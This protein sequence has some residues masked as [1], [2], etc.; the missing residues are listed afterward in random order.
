[1]PSLKKTIILCVLVFAVGSFLQ[2]T[3]FNSCARADVIFSEDFEGTPPH[4]L[5]DAVTASRPG[6]AVWSHDAPTGWTLDNSNMGDGGTP[7][8]WGLSFV[9]KDWW[10]NPG[11]GRTNFTLGTNTI[12]VGESDEWDDIGHTG[13]FESYL[14]TK[15][16]NISGY[17]QLTL[18]FD[19]SW[20]DE[21]NQWVNITVSYDGGT[22][23]EVLRWQSEASSEY[24]KGQAYNE[25]V[26]VP[27]PPT[28]AQ[29]L[30]ITFGYGDE[31]VMNDWWWAFDNIQV[32]GTSSFVLVS[33]LELS[34]SE[35]PLSAPGTY[36]IVLGTAPTHSVE[37][38]ATPSDAQI[39]LG[40]GAGSAITLTFTTGNWNNSQTVTVTGFDDDVF[41]GEIPH[42]SLISHTSQSDDSTFVG[43]TIATV[44]AEVQDDD[45][46]CG[47]WG[48]Y[49]ADLNEDC[50]VDLR[51]FAR[52]ALKWLNTAE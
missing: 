11:Q 9:N 21:D 19:S 43:I 48:Y 34:V 13:F 39:D 40:S 6:T 50:Y 51:D 37:V 7:E 46:I 35:D 15:E 42:T 22:P 3:L 45:K 23:I 27:L 30:V 33:P 4:P 29:S 52:F 41:E 1:M 5:L 20:D 31:G 12:C 26:S 44:T 36:E 49:Q 10:D 25:T 8:Y 32:T 24:Y 47:D 28:S 17:T 18:V 38:T 14:S 2:G 16:I